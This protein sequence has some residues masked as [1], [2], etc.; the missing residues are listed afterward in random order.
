MTG[1]MMLVTTMKHI[2]SNNDTGDDNKAKHTHSN[3]DNMGATRPNGTTTQ[4][5]GNARKWGETMRG[6][7]Q[8]KKRPRRHQS[9]SLEPLVSFFFFSFHVF[10][11]NL[12][13]YVLELLMT[14]V[15]WH[16]PTPLQATAWVGMGATPKRQDNGNTTTRVNMPHPTG[17]MRWNEEMR[18]DKDSRKTIAG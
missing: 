1:G 5:Q 2:H 9:M 15:S 10:V 17:E 11:T 14:K 8:T 18:W 3:D 16:P 13:R 6:T 4:Q 7:K 12:F